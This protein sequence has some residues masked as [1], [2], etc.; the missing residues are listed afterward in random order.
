MNNYVNFKIRLKEPDLFNDAEPPEDPL[1]EL[2][3]FQLGIRRFCFEC[4]HVVVLEIG[5]EKF[6]VFLDPDICM[7]LESGLPEQIN[8]LSQGQQIQID[9]FESMCLFLV[10]QPLK[11]DRLRCTVKKIGYISEK[12]FTLKTS[13]RLFELNQTQVLTE[14]KQFLEQLMQ[15][16]V[17][18][19]YITGEEKQGFLM[20]LREV[21]ATVG[22]V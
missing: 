17:T 5:A 12:H 21:V 9:F 7:I 6:Q 20:P 10:F 19:G 4:N 2:T 16:A 18:G 13:D 14:L 15:M 22:I 1:G 3:H 11:S 8:Q